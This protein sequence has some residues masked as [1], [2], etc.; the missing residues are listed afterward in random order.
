M[1]RRKKGYKAPEGLVKIPK[2]SNWY[3]KRTVNGKDIFKST[4]TS[5][6]IQAEEIYHMVMSEILKDLKE[7]ACNRILGKSV[8]FSFVVERYLREISPSKSKGGRNDKNS[9][10]PLLKRFG[11][12]KIDGITKQDIYKYLD[13]RK[14]S[15]SEKTGNPLSGSSI[16]REKSFLSEIFKKAIR[17][18]YIDDNL[19]LGIEGYSE[20]KRERYLTDEEFGGALQNMKEDHSDM[21]LTVYH[22]AQRTG[23]IYQLGWPQIDLEKRIVRFENTSKNKR[24]PEELW[25]NDA[26]CEILLKRKRNRRTLSPYVFY[27]KNLKPYND[28][29]ARK[30][31]K[32]ACEKANIDNSVPYDIRHKAITDMKKA[33]F[34]DAFVSHV[35]AQ[36]DPRTI[37]RYTHFSAEETKKPLEALTK[38]AMFVEIKEK[39]NEP[40]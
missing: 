29:G 7:N 6:L 30:I 24:V 14:N 22:T 13:W 20:N 26:L 27:S 31:W 15:V 28:S 18:G 36:S 5:D 35:T 21:F 3:I 9:S 38:K 37:K 39:A 16:N 32:K 1:G 33:G 34:N 17:W 12:S 10:K 40:R 2:S 8:P 4:G 11:D 19:V 23:R 25:I